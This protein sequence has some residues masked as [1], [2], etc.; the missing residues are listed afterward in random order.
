QLSWAKTF[1]NW[2][3]QHWA[4]VGWSDECYMVISNLKGTVYVTRGPGEEYSK[5][6]LRPV[7]KKSRKDIMVWGCIMLGV[8]GP[9]VMMEYPG[10]KGGGVTGERYREQILDGALRDFWARMTQERRPLM[11]QQDGAPAHSQKLTKKWLEDHLICLFPHPL[12]SPNISPI[13]PLWIHFNSN[14]RNHPHP[15]TSVQE[16]KTAAIEAWAS[17][18]QEK[19]NSHIEKMP[20]CVQALLKHWGGHILF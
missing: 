19:I 18:P 5:E 6:C 14:I 15:P 8:N 1:K 4:K 7:F 13:E 10:G 9:L 12:A 17:I 11:F 2:K 16:L 3:L 20:A